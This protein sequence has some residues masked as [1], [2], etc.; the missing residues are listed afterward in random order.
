MVLRFP[1]RLPSL[2]I[3]YIDRRELAREKK[4]EEEASCRGG[5]SMTGK[6]GRRSEVHSKRW[7]KDT[8]VYSS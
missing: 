2:I 5:A 6:R 4:K 1:K 3:L 7:N 8:S